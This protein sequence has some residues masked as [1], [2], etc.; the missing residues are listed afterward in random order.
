MNLEDD[1]TTAAATGNTAAVQ[2]LLEN[3][4]VKVNG[5]NRFG[6][7]ALQV[8]MM[9]SL[10]VAQLLLESGADPNVRDRSTGATPL[11]DAA[12]TGFADTARLLVQY[13]ADPNIRD[14]QNSRPIDVAKLGGHAEVIA[15][16]DTL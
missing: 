12:R 9:G 5:E 14:N 7:T 1:L 3:T 10:P 15:F 16:L 11:H 13:H 2:Y 8:M 6:R 4:E